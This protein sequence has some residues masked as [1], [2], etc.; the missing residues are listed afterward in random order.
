LEYALVNYASRS[1]AQRLAKRKQKKQVE[2]DKCAFDP[3]HMEEPHNGGSFPMKPMMRGSPGPPSGMRGGPGP[4]FANINNIHQC[5]IHM[6]PRKRKNFLQA[7]LNKFPSRA[8]KIDV[9]ARVIFPAIFAFF[10]MSYWTFYLTQEANTDVKWTLKATI[11]YETS[12]CSIRKGGFTLELILRLTM[13]K[14]QCRCLSSTDV[15]SKSKS[16]S[17]NW[18][19][20]PLAASAHADVD[21]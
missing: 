11:L 16:K 19:E 12:A 3:E 4:N 13:H 2:L 14:M 9:L 7:W 1:D 18:Q 6:K 5:E 20:G 21:V 8:K 17:K 10:N 15:W